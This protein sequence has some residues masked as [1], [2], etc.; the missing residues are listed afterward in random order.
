[1]RDSACVVKKIADD[2]M[3]KVLPAIIMAATLGFKEELKQMEFLATCWD[4]LYFKE[5]DCCHVPGVQ[6]PEPVQRVRRIGGVVN[7]QLRQF[8]QVEQCAFTL[9]VV[10]K[11]SRERRVG[12]IE[13]P[14]LFRL[15]S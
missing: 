14:F 10:E 1:M 2:A 15:Q 13:T 3:R 5:R 12:C 4:C 7:K 8:A 6:E 11:L 9:L